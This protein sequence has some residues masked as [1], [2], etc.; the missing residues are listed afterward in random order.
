MLK[1]NRGVNGMTNGSVRGKLLEKQDSAV[2]DTGATSNVYHFDI[3]Q[4][5]QQFTKIRIVDNCASREG[6]AAQ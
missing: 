1:S 5:P 4:Q 2:A 3:G 6:D